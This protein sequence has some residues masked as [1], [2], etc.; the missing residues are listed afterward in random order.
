MR[1]NVW[2]LLLTLP[3]LGSFMSTITLPRSFLSS[4]QLEALDGEFLF[5]ETISD[6]TAEEV[7]DPLTFNTG[8]PAN[9]YDFSCF[10]VAVT[11]PGLTRSNYSGGTLISPTY[12]VVA[13]HSPGNGDGF[14][15]KRKD[16]GVEEF[17]TRVDAV[18]IDGDLAI[19]KLNAPIT[20]IQPAVVLAD[21][22]NISGK[23]ALGM[24]PNRHLRLCVLGWGASTGGATP[25]DNT[26]EEIYSGRN[27]VLN[28]DPPNNNESGKPVFVPVAGRMALAVTAIT[29]GI[30]A[31]DWKFLFGPNISHY[32]TEINAYLAGSSESLTV[33]EFAP[34]RDGGGVQASVSSS[35]QSQIASYGEDD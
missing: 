26:Y 18:T 33:V 9:D 7:D 10:T 4:A 35:I 3:L 6:T 15:F 29:G 12:M 16:T 2:R 5:N 30:D 21:I 14:Y 13:T 22:S 31:T 25:I 11:T 19:I 23:L 24:E 34:I 32:I 28:G 20:T 17:R 27:T 8:S 1:N